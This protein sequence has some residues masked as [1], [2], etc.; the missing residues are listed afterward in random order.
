MIYVFTDQQEELKEWITAH[1][2]AP[3][4]TFNNSICIGIAEGGGTPSDRMIGAVAYHNGKEFHNGRLICEASIAT[5]SPK[6]ATRGVL[7]AVFGYPFLN[8]GVV[9]LRTT[10]DR[11]RKKIRKFNERLGF[12]YEGIARKLF[13]GERD[14]AVYSMLPHE[15]KWLDRKGFH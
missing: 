5:T 10:C 7:R 1:L 8:L 11:K 3:A 4:G 9:C 6:W 15:C 13:D 14:A 12:K 2:N